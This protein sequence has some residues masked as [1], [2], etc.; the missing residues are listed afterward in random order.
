LSGAP[1]P[2]AVGGTFVPRVQ[3]RGSYPRSGYDP[4]VAN[5]ERG[6]P[7]HGAHAPGRVCT[8]VCTVTLPG[9]APPGGGGGGA[10]KADL[11]L[12]KSVHSPL[13]HLFLETLFFLVPPRGIFRDPPLPGGPPPPTPPWPGGEGSQ[14]PRRTVTRLC[15]VN[16]TCP[17]DM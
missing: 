15:P 1:G 6:T 7:C 10:K 5:S 16:I 3:R 17:A 12:Y 14:C 11:A 2:W 4:A 9:G 13:E 8:K